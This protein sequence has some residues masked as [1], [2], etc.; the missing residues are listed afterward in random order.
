MAGLIII[1]PVCDI[2]IGNNYVT[3]QARE[4]QKFCGISRLRAFYVSYGLR[5]CETLPIFFL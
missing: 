3:F 5:V 2:D 4:R 1:F